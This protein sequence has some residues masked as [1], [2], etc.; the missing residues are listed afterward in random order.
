V[1]AGVGKVLSL[2]SVAQAEFAAKKRRQAPLRLTIPG[3]F[4]EFRYYLLIFPPFSPILS[5][6]Y[7][8]G[9]CFFAPPPAGSAFF[10]L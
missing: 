4:P 5:Y 9:M 10:S 2:G 1:W 6:M 8:I 3:F 7:F